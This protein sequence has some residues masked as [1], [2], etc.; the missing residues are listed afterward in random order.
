MGTAMSRNISRMSPTHIQGTSLGSGRVRASQFIGNWAS[1]PN[2][3]L[4]AL[5]ARTITVGVVI[6][7]RDIKSRL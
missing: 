7:D 5:W 3:R 4:S 2:L 1:R 6:R